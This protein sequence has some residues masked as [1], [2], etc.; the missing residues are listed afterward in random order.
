MALKFGF[1]NSINGDRTYNAD[2]MTKPYN[3]I[4]SNGV[5]AD[6]N[7]T[8]GFKVESHSGLQIK[9]NSGNGLFKNKWC[10]LTADELLTVPTPNVSYPR[11]DS[12]VLRVDEN[13]RTMS[14]EYIQG[15][16][17]GEPQ[18]P[19]ISN[20][21]LVKDYRFANI[22]VPAN[23]M[24]ISP[25]N[26]DDTRYGSECGIVS[27]LLQNSDLTSMYSQWESNF[28]RWLSENQDRADGDRSQQINDFENAQN[29]RAA[30]FESFLDENQESIDTKK[31][32][33]EDWLYTK[34]AEFQAWFDQQKEALNDI[35][36]LRQFVK[37]IIVGEYDDKMT[38]P[39]N[40]TVYNMES[41]I[42][43]V[44]I[45]GLLAVKGVDFLIQ[46]YEKIVLTKAVDAGTQITFVLL[47]TNGGNTDVDYIEELWSNISE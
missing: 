2:D 29:N 1:F 10:E 7:G 12:V 39:I 44:Y 4:V 43:N 27:N 23:A 20:N 21:D 26:I 45:N 34:K 8:T 19:A 36:P 40:M 28:F 9:V 18:I 42:L 17:S 41:D 5:F 14:L 46:S 33:F 15:T 31:Q 11:I 35:T 37:N 32:E 30:T 47:K 6:E 16:P 13:N 24:T 3:R 22:T 38:I 25:S